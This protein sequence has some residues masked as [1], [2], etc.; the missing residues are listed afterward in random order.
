ME[1]GGSGDGIIRDMEEEEEQ[2]ESDAGQV[3]ILHPGWVMY[4][5]LIIYITNF[6]EGDPGQGTNLFM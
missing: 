3:V 6:R 5:L 2:R 1:E 4:V